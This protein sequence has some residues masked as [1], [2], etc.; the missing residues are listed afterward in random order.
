MIRTCKVDKPSVCTPGLSASWVTQLQMIYENVSIA[1]ARTQAIDEEHTR[2]ESGIIKPATTNI[3]NVLRFETAF[4]TFARVCAGVISCDFV[5][6]NDFV[7]KLV[8][9]KATVQAFGQSV[10]LE[11]LPKQQYVAWTAFKET[12]K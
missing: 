5:T 7:T 9:I 11:D 12:N 10:E 1:E 2:W 3:A 4:A 6:F 8:E